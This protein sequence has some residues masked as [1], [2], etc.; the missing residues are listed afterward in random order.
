MM[1]A[2][3]AL[4]RA[5]GCGVLAALLGGVAMTLTLRANEWNLTALP[6]VDAATSLGAAAR[7]I[8][9]GFRTLHPGAYDGQF[10]WGIAIDPLATVAL[11]AD[12]DKPSYRYGHPLY[13]WLAWILS[14]GRARAAPAALAAIGLGALFAAAALAGGIGLARGGS[15]WEGLVVA[16][17]PGLISSAAHDLAE[18]LAAVLLLAALAAHARGR[19]AAAWLCLAS[20]PLAKEPLLLAVAAVVVWEL[21][22]R[23]ARRAALFATAAIPALA[24]WIYARI[25]LGAW[26]TSGDSALA[27]PLAGWRQA[28]LAG[29]VDPRGSPLRHD[30]ALTGLAALLVVLLLLGARA[31]RLRRPVEIVY[32]VLAALA[33]CLAPNALAEFTTALRN[34]AFL[35]LLAPFLLSSSVLMP[36]LGETAL[37]GRL[38]RDRL[39]LSGRA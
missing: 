36:R 10:Y 8:D 25:Q 34:T 3:R 16:L 14:G 33:L 18:P 2:R 23:A 20:L 4:V 30:A 9:P 35:V 17:N 28:L 6:R 31:L 21:R 12:F 27:S 11:H 7:A 39:T 29:G 13:G 22:R 26:F 1:P 37:R 24:W 38:S 32:V 5:L 19:L 15:G